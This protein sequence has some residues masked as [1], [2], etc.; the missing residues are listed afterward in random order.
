MEDEICQYGKYGYCKFK[1]ECKQK[2][3]SEE[4][5]DL[6]NCKIIKSCTKRHPKRCKK[7]DSEKCR[8]G[9]TC[10]YKHLESTKNKEYDILKEKVHELEQIVNME[11]TKNK[12]SDILKE[13]LQKVEKVVHALTRKVLSLET[14]LEKVERENSKIEECKEPKTKTDN[15]APEEFFSQSKGSLVP[16]NVRDSRKEKVNDMEE[17]VTEENFKPESSSASTPKKSSSESKELEEKVQRGEMKQIV[18]SCEQCDYEAKKEKILKKHIN[19]K[20]QDQVCKECKEK[21]KSFMELLKHVAKHHSMEPHEEK[22][23]S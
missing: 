10:A 12:D 19:T 8:F 2:H 6:E 3:L 16:K 23:V 21:F 18:F 5:E 11:K 15:K 14:K 20:H 7:H 4:C 22:D 1:S 17:K 9:E 13:K